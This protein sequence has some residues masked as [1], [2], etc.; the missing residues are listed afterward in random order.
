MTAKTTSSNAERLE[1]YKILIEMADRVSQ[2]R[3]SANS[4]Y[5]TV[6]TALIGGTSLM[7]KDGISAWSGIAL[8]AAGLSIALLWI[9]NIKSYKTLND[10]KFKVIT[11]IETH[12]SYQAYTKEW[13]FLDPDGDGKRHNPFHKVE[14]LVPLVFITAY[15]IN[16]SI[17]IPWKHLVSIC[18]C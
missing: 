1:I 11:D 10:A 15:L 4:F 3:Q 5:L 12:L 14:S 16:I 17:Y 9:R 6:N 13:D 7:S 18:G 2:R 8:S